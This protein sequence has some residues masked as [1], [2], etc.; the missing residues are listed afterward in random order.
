[1]AL[2]ASVPGQ[3]LHGRR[4]GMLRFRVVLR[5]LDTVTARF[6]RCPA[7][8]EQLVPA[9]P[10]AVYRLN[11]KAARAIPPGGRE[12]FAI[13][14]RVPKDAPLGANGLFWGLDPLGAR[15]PQLNAR[16]LVAVGE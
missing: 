11:C 5:N 8:V 9:G 3:P 7:H 15:S 16:V 4:G 6:G 13:E 2:R 10:V 14:L 12:A 1:M